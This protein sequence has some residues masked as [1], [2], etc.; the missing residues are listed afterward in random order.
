MA[1]W[2]HSFGR[3]GPVILNVVTEPLV[4]DGKETQ[5]F[6]IVQDD[7]EG[8]IMVDQDDGFHV[9]LRNHLPVPTSIHW[10]G[11]ILPNSQDGVPYVTQDPIPPGGEQEY[12]FPLLQ[13]GT[14]WMHSHYGLQE[15]VL[16][17]A[18]LIIMNEAERA[19]ADEQVVVFL[20]DFTSRRPLEILR[21]LQKPAAEGMDMKPEA[22]ERLVQ[23]WD[24]DSERFTSTSSK[25]E[26]ANIDVQYEALIAN[27]RT[28]SDPDVVPVR[29]GDSVLLRIIAGSSATNFF[30]DT[31]TLEAELLATDGQAVE[32]L[33]G[34]FFQLAVAQR[35]DLRVVI[36]ADG[37]AFPILALGEG[38]DL[39][40]G[41]V[42]A[43]EGADVPALQSRGQQ[44]GPLDNT[45]ETRLR[46]AD[47]LPERA[48]DRELPSQLG[49]DMSDYRWSING[50]VYPNRDS[51]DVKEGERVQMTIANKTMMSHPMHLHGH[52]FHVVEIDGRPLRGAK[53]DTVLVPPG[54]VTKI[55]FD[56]DNIGVWAYHCHILYHLA[57]GM[58]TVVKY[59]GADT[60]FWQPEKTHLE[61][62]EELP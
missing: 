34:N 26:P 28:L 54:G 39:R 46:A 6:G 25:G 50:N 11:L 55:Q 9:L 8:G 7:G 61:L 5:V 29:A 18:P 35:M 30:I 37:G 27:R 13:H 59:E 22:V 56:A 62:E 3:A 10:H 1:V 48:V 2:L 38:T 32:P 60:G 19:K 53:R 33:S 49:G 36:P 58:F 45:Q 21:E 43:T 20:S 44:A 4:I 14:Y 51:L 16:A 12:Q 52:D 40:T 31:G 41:I 23:V 47:P 15:Q 42:L 17:S 57:S 24:A